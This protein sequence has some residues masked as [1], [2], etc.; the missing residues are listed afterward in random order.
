MAA[1]TDSGFVHILHHDSY[2]YKH[3]VD[4][5][6]TAAVIS[7]TPACRPARVKRQG[8]EGMILLG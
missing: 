1:V 7:Y 4:S 5:S 8:G 6:L 3:A 2:G